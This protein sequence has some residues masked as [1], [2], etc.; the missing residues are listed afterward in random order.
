[1]DQAQCPQ[2]REGYMLERFEDELLLYHL[3]N[4]QTVYLN[5]SAA[6]VWE[7]CDGKTSIADMIA[8]LQEQ[9]PDAAA[10]IEDDVL[11]TVARLQKTGAMTL[12]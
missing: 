12:T 9:F 5:A 4:T 8:L 3:D 11:E 1:M 2:R 7:L 10:Q 6:L